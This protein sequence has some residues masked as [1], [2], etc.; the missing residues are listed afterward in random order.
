MTLKGES[1][2]NGMA[3]TDL[4]TG[5]IHI[6]QTMLSINHVGVIAIMMYEL[7]H[8]VSKEYYN[9]FYVQSCS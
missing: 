2:L 7:I 9:S 4:E 5:D 3:Y 6:N 1:I 8:S